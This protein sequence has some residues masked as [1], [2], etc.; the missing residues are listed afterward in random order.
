MQTELDLMV[1]SILNRDETDIAIIADKLKELHDSR[2]LI[3]IFKKL[4]CHHEMIYVIDNSESIQFILV[5]GLKHEDILKF[6]KFDSD[7]NVIGYFPV[8]IGMSSIAELFTIE[9][10]NWI[11]PGAFFSYGEPTNLWKYT[12]KEIAL[13]LLENKALT[14]PH[15]NL[16]ITEL[17]NRG[18]L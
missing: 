17:L 7:N 8:I 10:Y 14:R 9:L 15:I 2:D 18:W 11:H 4:T 3:Y 5:E 12:T 13:Y 1:R 16:F 6:L